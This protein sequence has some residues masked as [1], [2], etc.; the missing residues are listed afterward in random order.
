MDKSTDKI[1]IIFGKRTAIYDASATEEG[2]NLTI[3]EKGNV[4]WQLMDILPNDAVTYADKR[5][6]HRLYFSTWNG[7]GITLN[8]DSLE[9]V[10]KQ[11]VK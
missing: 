3:L 5:D 8:V 7:L 9:V 11:V 1:K 2:N 6:E 10:E 4:V